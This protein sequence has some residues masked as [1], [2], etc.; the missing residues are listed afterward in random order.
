[1]APTT[2]AFSTPSH[3]EERKLQSSPVVDIP[4]IAVSSEETDTAFLYPEFMGP[5]MDFSNF[6]SFASSHSAPLSPV[7]SLATGKHYRKS[8]AVPAARLHQGVGRQWGERGMQEPIG[9]SSPATTLTVSEHNETYAK[10]DRQ[11]SNANGS[12]GSS[13]SEACV[14]DG[15]PKSSFLDKL[16]AASPVTDSAGSTP[17][18]RSSLQA[19]PQQL[20]S[21]SQ[22]RAA[23]PSPFLAAPIPRPHANAINRLSCPSP[24]SPLSRGSSPLAELAELASQRSSAASSPL[25]PLPHSVILAPPSQQPKRE[26]IAASALEKSLAEALAHQLPNSRPHSRP[27]SALSIRSTQSSKNSPSRSAQRRGLPSR[28]KRFPPSALRVSLP[29][30]LQSSSGSNIDTTHLPK[31]PL[32][33]KET[34]GYATRSRHGVSR[35]QEERE[36]KERDAD[37][38]LIRLGSSVSATSMK[39]SGNERMDGMAL[40]ILASVSVVRRLNVETH[41]LDRGRGERWSRASSLTPLSSS[42]ATPSPTVATHLHPALGNLV[43]GRGR[44]ETRGV[45][46]GW[47]EGV[48]PDMHMGHGKDGKKKKTTAKAASRASSA[49]TPGQGRKPTKAQVVLKTRGPVR[50]GGKKPEPQSEDDETEVE[51][52]ELDIDAEGET[53]SEDEDNFEEEEKMNVDGDYEPSPASLSSLKPKGKKANSRVSVPKSKAIA[54]PKGK[55]EVEKKGAGKKRPAP[56]KAASARSVTA[57]RPKTSRTFSSLSALSSASGQALAVDVSTPNSFSGSSQNNLDADDTGAED[58]DLG[59]I[60]IPTRTFPE[61]VPVHSAFPLLYRQFP[62]CSFVGGISVASNGPI[63]RATGESSPLTPAPAT[64]QSSPAVAS[65]SGASNGNALALIEPPSSGNFNSHAALGVNDLYTP[66]FVRGVGREKTGLCPIC[67]EDE[68]RGGNGKQEWLSMKFS[69]F[70][71]VFLRTS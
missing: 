54:A 63:V 32:E 2:S 46:R 1:M 66:R 68:S 62:A 61:G 18:P 60:D 64:T 59:E 39:G 33:M 49:S 3:A 51:I 67:Y 11:T 22:S 26:M 55:A 36:K 8:P 4:R 20:D 38:E 40:D 70:K 71:W 7:E 5:E 21:Q 30:P 16:R 56:R 43:N 12:T 23:S 58:V 47:S 41:D 28:A 53:V 13:G 52:D 19:Q 29:I 14:V 15:Q 10:E 17:A 65:S 57:S 24:L 42:V 31:G 44:R 6:P 35:S 45:K 37:L 69:A 9:E 27:G 50:R 34:T 25:T 48:E